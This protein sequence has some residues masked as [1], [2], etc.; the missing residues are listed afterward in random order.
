MQGHNRYWSGN[1]TYAKQN[2]GQWDFLCNNNTGGNYGHV[3][4][5]T[6]Q[7]FWDFLLGSSRK[8]GLTTYEQV[9]FIRMLSI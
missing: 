5:P 2:G 4:V 6:Q 1:T 7:E 9:P 8:W 3:C